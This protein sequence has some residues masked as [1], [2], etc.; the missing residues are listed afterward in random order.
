MKHAVA[1]APKQNQIATRPD[2]IAEFWS[3]V[4]AVMK[5]IEERAFQLFEERGREDGHDME[6]WFKAEQE[7]LVSIPVTITEKGD[8]LHIHA[9]VPGFAAKEIALN[10]E[11]DTLTLQGKHIETRIETGEA[12]GIQSEMAADILQSRAARQCNSGKGKGNMEGWHARNHRSKSCRQ[13]IHHRSGPSG[14]KNLVGR[15]ATTTENGRVSPLELCPRNMPWS[16][17]NFARSLRTL[18][19]GRKS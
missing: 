8:D 7:L 15:I 10:L 5:Q 3:R 18:T 19:K 16:S 12:G 2:S 14:L 4:D 17:M 6:D 1:L 13:I 11:Q 9:E